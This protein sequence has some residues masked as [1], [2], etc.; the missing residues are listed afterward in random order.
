[1]GVLRRMC[2]DMTLVSLVPFSLWNCKVSDIVV[3][4]LTAALSHNNTLELLR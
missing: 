3:E 4:A 2:A 1:M